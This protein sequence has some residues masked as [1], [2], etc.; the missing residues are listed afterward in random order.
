[1]S[2]ATLDVFKGVSLWAIA[3]VIPVI[4]MAVK[5]ATV[6]I[7]LL[8]LIYPTMLSFFCRFG[9]FWVSHGVTYAACGLTLLFAWLITLSPQA[10]DAIEN[11]DKNEAIAGSVMGAIIA[12]FLIIMFVASKWGISMYDL[13][14]FNKNNNL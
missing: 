5:N 10:K 12:L 11:P 9:H 3:M 13:S 14:N 6:R 1:M 7:L 2:T 8:T 4:M